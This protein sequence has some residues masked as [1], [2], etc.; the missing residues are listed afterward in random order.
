MLHKTTPNV[1]ILFVESYCAAL[2]HARRDRY[3]V[4]EYYGSMLVYRV[5]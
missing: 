5:I 4:H 1:E 2:G 3:R